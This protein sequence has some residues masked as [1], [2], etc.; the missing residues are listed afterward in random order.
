[1]YSNSVKSTLDSFAVK[2]MKVKFCR[3]LQGAFPNL[4]VYITEDFQDL[5]I[6]KS[7]SGERWHWHHQPLLKVKQVF[8][9]NVM[10]FS[11]IDTFS[12]PKQN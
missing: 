8:G 9:I 3:S 7:N 6:N 4:Y 12:G 5:L 10:R 2:L 11:G 1:M